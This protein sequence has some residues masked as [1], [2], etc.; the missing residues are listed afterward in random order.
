MGSIHN[1]LGELKLSSLKT[2]RAILPKARR[3]YVTA[4]STAAAK[5]DSIEKFLPHDFSWAS[6]YEL[7]F[8]EMLLLN[9]SVLGMLEMLI[10]AYHAGL[11]LNQYLMDFTIHEAED[12]DEGKDWAGG[13]G[14]IYTEDD[15]LGT[16]H[17]FQN[18]WR[19]MSIYGHFLNDLVKQVR[20][21]GKEAEDAFFNAVRIDRTILN[22]PTFAARLAR[23]EYFREKDFMQRLHRAIKEKPHDA[24]L[25]HQDLRTMLYVFQDLK[26]LD[27]LSLNETDL[28]FIKE[29]K[30]YQDAGKDPARSL[31]RFIQRWKEQKSPAT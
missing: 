17:A 5:R 13:H 18:S 9:L 20:G 26:I 14:G 7:E 29:L 22:C 6:L 3:K 2:L 8:K 31:M 28:L 27:D 10:Q 1:I 23:A 30:L 15:L 25:V 24:L 16:T 4:L 11:D 19:C 12:K 21:G